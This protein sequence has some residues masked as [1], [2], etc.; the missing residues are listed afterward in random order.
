MLNIITIVGRLTRDPEL[1]KTKSETSVASF[2]VACDD[3]RKAPDGSKQTVF[4]PVSV[5]GSQADIIMKFTKKGYLIGISG[6]LTQ[7]K[8]QNK[9]G[10]EITST[11]VIA[12][13]I[14]LMEPKAKE[15]AEGEA[16]KVTAPE[17]KT[18]SAV[19]PAGDD[20]MLDDD[21]PF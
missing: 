8:Y 19:K 9:Q 11:E 2:T 5:F 16:P 13:T 4:L 12:N 10:V 15:E 7:R 3:S 1:R 14:E 17:E 18:E 6:R 20:G 21:L